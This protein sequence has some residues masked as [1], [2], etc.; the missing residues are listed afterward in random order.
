VSNDKRLIDHIV[1][2]DPSQLGAVLKRRGQSLVGF[3][4]EDIGRVARSELS[5]ALQGLVDRLGRELIRCASD[6]RDVEHDA[7]CVRNIFETNLIVRYI[8][9]SPDNTLHWLALRLQEEIDI[10]RS[11]STLALSGEHQ[12]QQS[13]V[14]ERIEFLEEIL[15]ERGMPRPPR[16][17]RWSALALELGCEADYEALYGAYSKYVHPSAWTI[18]RPEPAWDAIFAKAFL[19]HSQLY[20]VDAVSRAAEALGLSSD[21]L[22]TDA[23]SRS[24]LANG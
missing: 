8:C 12:D 16:L 19:V 9:K 13:R 15:R 1:D 7:R 14:R 17:P 22:L 4:A 23:W 10:L 20:A 24:A 3:A 5:A 11:T 21:R 2:T 6:P 18:V